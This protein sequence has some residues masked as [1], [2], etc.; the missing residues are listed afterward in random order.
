MKYC[1]KL[2]AHTVFICPLKM[3][4]KFSNS[5]GKFS[6]I[7]GTNVISLFVLLGKENSTNNLNLAVH[8]VNAV[9]KVNYKS[10]MSYYES[11]L[12]VNTLVSYY[13]SG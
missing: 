12:T 13:H 1:I 6:N 7:S 3:L 2:Y 9:L 5:C 4:R 11:N 10:C 8:F